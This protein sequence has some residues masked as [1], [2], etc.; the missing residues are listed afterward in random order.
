MVYVKVWG[1]E[2]AE[3]YYMALS[4]LENRTVGISGAE[5]IKIIFKKGVDIVAN[6]LYNVVS[7]KG[8]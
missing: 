6:Y 7:Y 2:N 4:K 8:R 5:Q 1:S 3:K